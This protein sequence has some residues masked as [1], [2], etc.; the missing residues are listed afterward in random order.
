MAKQQYRIYDSF[1]WMS[2]SGN[3]IVV[4][5][6]PPGSGKKLT[7]S[8]FELQNMTSLNPTAFGSAASP[9]NQLALAKFSSLETGTL[10]SPTQLDSESV[11]PTTVKVSTGAICSGQT[12]VRRVAVTKQLVAG[13]TSWISRQTHLGN[14]GQF[15]KR[16]HNAPAL[17]NYTVKA[18]E[19]LS[20]FFS[21]LTSVIPLRVYVLLR[22]NGQCFAFTEFASALTQGQTL[23]SIQ[24]DVG[25][26]D[27]VEVV[28]LS[29]EEVGTYDSPYF[30]LVPAGQLDATAT[31]DPTKSVTPYKMDSNYPSAPF[32]V[33]KD[34]PVLPLGVPENYLSGASTGSPKGFNYLKTKDFLGPVYRTVFPENEGTNSHIAPTATS[35]IDNLGMYTSQ[36][37]SDVF[38]RGAGITINEGEGVALVS[39]A[40]TAVTANPVGTSGWSA[41][42]IGATITVESKYSP[43]LT[44]SGLK[45]GTEV[46]VYDDQGDELAGVE[47]S[48]TTFQYSYS[49]DGNISTTIVI[50]SLGYLPIRLENFILG[51]E[52]QTVPIQQIV[53]RQYT[54]LPGPDLQVVWTEDWESR[55]LGNL[56]ATTPVTALVGSP[57]VVNGVIDGKAVESGPTSQKFVVSVAGLTHWS[58]DF[59]V[60]MSGTQT[61]NNY[62]ASVNDSAGAYVGDINLRLAEKQIWNR[63]NFGAD[64]TL[65]RSTL[66]YSDPGPLTVRIVYEWY[67]DQYA[68]THLY[69]GS[70]LNGSTPDQTL[71]FDN[72]MAAA[73]LMGKRVETMR[74]G[75]DTTTGIV[76]QFDNLTLRNLSV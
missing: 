69:Y 25:S 50:H 15:V 7:L 20:L 37:M 55:A 61:G 23:L 47:S 26:T 16:P 52:S 74:F 39:G 68:K 64:P 46:R 70:N 44:L 51:S 49:Y 24:N 73:Q 43:T 42:N 75:N 22:V 5:Y 53:D 62:I 66:T 60:S 8:Q 32:L 56:A 30:Q 3:G 18:G 31:A 57:T 54:N 67:N 6:N 2:N 9:A 10:L 19:N 1:D 63:I 36:K 13:N 45:P 21:A 29:V 34:I 40:E 41:W 59:T 76:Q 14:L 65:G 58:I 12:L 11:W 33:Y 71:L 27:I 17:Q 28:E 72:V 35:T 4:I 48:G 38:V